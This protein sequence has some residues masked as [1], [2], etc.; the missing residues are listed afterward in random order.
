[1]RIIPIFEIRKKETAVQSHEPQMNLRVLGEFLS[2]CPNDLTFVL[3]FPLL[4]RDTM[5]KVPLIKDNI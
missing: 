5:H 4:K 2:V 3:E 1:M